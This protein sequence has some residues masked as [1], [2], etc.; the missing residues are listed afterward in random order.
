MNKFH[1]PDGTIPERTALL[2]SYAQELVAN[3]TLPLDVVDMREG[4]FKNISEGYFLLNNAYK[5]WR[6]PDGHRT[7]LPK[8]AALQCV[9]ISRYQPFFPLVH[10]VD[11][12]DLVAAKPN[13]VFAALYALGILEINF[14][15]DTL[16]KQDFWLRL[17]DVISSTFSQTLEPYQQDKSFKIDQPFEYYLDLIKSIHQEDKPAISA[18]ICIFELMS[19]K[20]ETLG[21]NV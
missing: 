17:L 6:I 8:I 1:V 11:E 21:F 14:K 5:G 12:L 7:E 20:R 13:E 10:P 3:G 9:T 16:E 4:R 15:P 2:L 18:L 19:K